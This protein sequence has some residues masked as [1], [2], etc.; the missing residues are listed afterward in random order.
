MTTPKISVRTTGPQKWAV[1]V[2]RRATADDVR[3]TLRQRGL[4][5]GQIRKRGQ[6]YVFTADGGRLEDHRSSQQS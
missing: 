5:C 1:S 2:R 6:E 3:Q 4:M